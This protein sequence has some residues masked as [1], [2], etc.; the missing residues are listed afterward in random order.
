LQDVRFIETIRTYLN[1][2][3][4]VAPPTHKLGARRDLQDFNDFSFTRNA[5]SRLRWSSYTETPVIDRNSY[6]L[7]KRQMHRPTIR[8]PASGLCSLSLTHTHAPAPARYMPAS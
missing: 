4:D 2:Q 5:L 8:K 3:Q 1:H 7:N 6:D